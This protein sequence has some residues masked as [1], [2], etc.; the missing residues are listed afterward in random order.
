MKL[1]VTAQMDGDYAILQLEGDLTLGP[2]LAALREAAKQA[3]SNS[4]PTGLILRMG[5]VTQMDSSGLG[6]LTIIYSFA[7]K[8]RCPLRLVGVSPHVKKILE[9]T[10]LDELLKSSADIASAKM[11]LRA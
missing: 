1:N 11:E 7:N 8:Q 4:K 5:G 2:S 9:M 3:L 10:R 6:E